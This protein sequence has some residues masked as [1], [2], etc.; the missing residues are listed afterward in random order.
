MARS[1]K[2]AG[3][4]GLALLARIVALSHVPLS[5]VALS[6]VASIIDRLIL[7]LPAPQ[8]LYSQHNLHWC[9]TMVNVAVD[10]ASGS[11]TAGDAGS[12]QYVV[13]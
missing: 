13:T 7:C 4:V 1:E 12:R 5:H 3:F 2:T 8:A 10:L 6:H 9:G 11:G